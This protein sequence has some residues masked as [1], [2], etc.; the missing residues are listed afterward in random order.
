LIITLIDFNESFK[1]FF[2]WNK[3]IRNVK[4]EDIIPEYQ[5][6]GVSS[7]EHLMAYKQILK[8]ERK[9]RFNFLHRRFNNE[10]FETETTIFVDKDNEHIY[11]TIIKDLTELKK[12][13]AALARS[14]SNL[15]NKNIVL[16]RYID[17]NV[18]LEN[19]AFMASHDLQSPLKTVK[20]FLKL[21]NQSLNQTLSERQNMF[22]DNINKS[23]NHME[24]LIKSLLNY[25]LV[26]TNNTKFAPIKVA[27]LI[28]NVTLSLNATIREKQAKIEMEDMPAQIKG[29][30]SRLQQLFQNLISNALKFIEENTI[31]IIKINFEDLDDYWKF[32]ISDNGIGISEENQDRIFNLFNR[33]HGPNAYKGNGI[34]LTM[35]K[36]I[37]EQHLGELNIHSVEGEGSTF[38]FTIYKNL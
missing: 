25:S 29:D 8:T 23:V 7:I 38:Y 24:I 21:F 37:V 1:K 12:K 17:S 3:T 10:I 18:E 22:M 34:G 27:Q 30:E 32:Y 2:C 16:Q 20:A 6:D 26:S 9:C 35:C 5:L 31:P 4:R 15:N 11:T 13:E 36:K 28:E 14:I 19:Y 33:L